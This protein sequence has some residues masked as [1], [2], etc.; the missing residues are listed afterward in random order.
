MSGRSGEIGA[1]V[2]SFVEK[3]ESNQDPGIVFL[4]KMEAFLA[5]LL[6]T[7]SWLLAFLDIVMVR[8]IRGI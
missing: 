6:L 3:L 5:H 7:K 2:L 4:Q 1:N 8:F